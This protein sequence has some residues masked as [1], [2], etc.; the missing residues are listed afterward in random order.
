MTIKIQIK[1]YLGTVLFELEKENNTIKDT[2]IEAVKSGANLRGA[3]L[4]GA[5]LS[6]VNLSRANL[7]GADLRGANLWGANLWGANLSG[8]NLSGVNLSGVK[9]IPQLYPSVLSLMKQQKNKLIA[10]KYVTS[11]FKSPTK[12]GLDYKI[13][14]TVKLNKKDCDYSELVE[15]GKGLHVATLEWCIREHGD[16]PVIEVE[17]DPK[18]IVSI[19]YATDGKFRIKKLKVLRVVPEKEIKKYA[20]RKIT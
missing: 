20:E 8:V 4:W 5:N 3:N 1:S 19:P 13:G 9:N 16:K 18:D 17:F 12:G 11:D 14:K 7:R 10:Y 6:G 2:L 15:C